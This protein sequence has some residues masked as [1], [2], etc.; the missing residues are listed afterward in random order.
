MNNGAFSD[1][2]LV[3]FMGS[4][5]RLASLPTKVSG[6]RPVSART[7]ATRPSRCSRVPRGAGAWVAV[8]LLQSSS[9]LAQVDL[10]AL[11]N[12][13]GF[14]YD[15]E[16]CDL[17][18]G[19]TFQAPGQVAPG[20]NLT[21]TNPVTD[22]PGEGATLPVDVDIQGTLNAIG[23]EL[24]SVISVASVGL[25][26]G[27]YANQD[28]GQSFVNADEFN[29]G[30]AVTLNFEADL[31]VS[32]LYASAPEMVYLGS[33]MY[34]VTGGGGDLYVDFGVGSTPALSND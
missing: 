32:D 23:S 2:N 22:Q 15:P 7:G 20:A 33:R 3:Q 34:A 17:S 16:A 10:P 5:R 21:A 12:Y 31:D 14:S 8:A 27:T 24:A 11:V 19:C 4:A 1:N 9:A 29:H 26:A 30:A 13:P 6:R 25:P 28:G 18:V